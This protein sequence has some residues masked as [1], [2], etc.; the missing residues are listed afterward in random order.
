[1]KKSIKTLLVLAS[2]TAF[3]ATQVEAAE[4]DVKHEVKSGDTMWKIAS[5]NG[6]SLAELIQSNP[7]VAN[8]N[9]IYIGEDI[10]LSDKPVGVTT[11]QVV[12]RS[13]PPT[14]NNVSTA[15]TGDEDLLAR[16]VH[17]EAKGESYAGKLAVAKVVLNRVASEKFPD[18]IQAVVY[19]SG[20]F[21]PVSNGA[22]NKPADAESIQAAKEAF[23]IGGN[24]DA[25][26]FFY[27][28]DIATNH[29]VGTRPVTAVIGNHVFA[30]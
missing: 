3:D 26:L 6:I 11:N 7:Q 21:S 19:Q 29:W 17:A 18:S 24:P 16:L 14:S 10:N 22:I 27:N 12:Q 28:P 20:Q 30:K 9:K 8:P 13:Q 25:A 5:Q 4:A 2:I 15:S 23:A 1:M